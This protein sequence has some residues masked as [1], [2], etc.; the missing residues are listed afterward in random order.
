MRP[1][2]PS[3]D[4]LVRYRHGRAIGAGFGHRRVRHSRSWQL[5]EVDKAP[6]RGFRLA[7]AQDADVRQAP[8]LAGRLRF[9]REHLAHPDRRGCDRERLRKTFSFVID[10]DA[11]S[12]PDSVTDVFDTP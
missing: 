7:L 2:A 5:D 1:R 4:V 10:T 3:K 11:Q 12:E 8:I 6:A 9:R